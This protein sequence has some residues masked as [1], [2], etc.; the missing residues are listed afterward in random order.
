MQY[1]DEKKKNPDLS[2]DEIF[3]KTTKAL[4]EHGIL[5]TRD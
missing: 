5:K 2:E 1:E 4:E 3:Q